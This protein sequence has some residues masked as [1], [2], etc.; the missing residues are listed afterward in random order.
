MI[1][2]DTFT[3]RSAGKEPVYRLNAL[4]P[5]LPARTVGKPTGSVQNG[6]RAALLL[7]RGGFGGRMGGLDGAETVPLHSG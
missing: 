5:A 3:V 6:M 2:P 1:L 7:A 4:P